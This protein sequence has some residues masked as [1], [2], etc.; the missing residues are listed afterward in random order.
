MKL[1]I[2]LLAIITTSAFAAET[3]HVFTWAD[4]INPDLVKQ[5]EKKHKCKVA[6]DTFDSNEAMYA[7]LKAGASGYDLIFPSSYIIPLMVQQ[8]MLQPLD[9][10]QL[11]NLKNVEPEVL[12][13][14]ADSAMK[15]SVPYTFGYAVIAY[16][17][18]KVKDI[19]TSWNTFARTDLKKRVTLL[20]DMRET[21]GAALKSLGYSL[22]TRDEK[23]LAAARDV[24]IAWKK[25]I[26]KFDNEG[27][28]AG[29]DSGEFNV[30]HGYSGDLWQVMQTNKKVGV[31]IPNEGVSASCD[32]M[33]IPKGA[34]NAALAHALIN[35]LL[36]G[37]VSAE[38]MQ[39]IGYLCPN[40]AGLKLV[41]NEF[42]NNPAVTIPADVKAK[43]EVIQD[44]GEDLKKYTKVWD[45][46]K[47]G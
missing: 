7:R 17:K 21:I 4:Y 8:D 33:V 16:R 5:F 1:L 13:K 25:N 24:L 14:I 30:V 41:E 46:V 42:L 9:H 34:P 26:A 6:I 31:V 12:G 47:A 43:S 29:V 15:H 23:E 10:A 37:K 19:A 27:Y 44:L 22:N 40:S 38:N 3:L 2:S 35:F 45:E 11:S 36:D 18:D 39:N 20:N 32:E 28:K